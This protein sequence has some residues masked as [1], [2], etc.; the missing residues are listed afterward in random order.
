MARHAYGGIA[1]QTSHRQSGAKLQK[2]AH[3]HRPQMPAL[4]PR[5]RRDR[6]LAP[7]RSKT[8]T[9]A[10]ER[11]SAGHPAPGRSDETQSCRGQSRPRVKHSPTCRDRRSPWS[12]E[13]RA[14]KRRRRPTSRLSIAS[15]QIAAG[16]S[17]KLEI[18]Q[19]RRAGDKIGSGRDGTSRSYLERSIPVRQR[20]GVRYHGWWGVGSFGWGR[21]KTAPLL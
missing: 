11:A 21:A 16:I 9:A 19:T 13:W 18:A 14:N 3:R 8:D 6:R 15:E 1:G 12:P 20:S 5:L 4:R 17:S 10:S 2:S 7:P